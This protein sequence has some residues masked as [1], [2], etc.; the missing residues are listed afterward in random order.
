MNEANQKPKPKTVDEIYA[1]ALQLPELEQDKLYW[2]LTKDQKCAVDPEVERAA[3]AECERR[4]ALVRAGRM[5]LLDADD[6]IHEARRI[7]DE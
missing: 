4:D 1:A 5:E 7:V 3:I 2:M 6:V